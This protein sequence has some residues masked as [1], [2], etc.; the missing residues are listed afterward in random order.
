MLLSPTQVSLTVLFIEA[1]E[2][3]ICSMSI[4]YI[5]L[6]TLSFTRTAH[7]LEAFRW[8]LICYYHQQSYEIAEDNGK[9]L[10][11]FR[12]DGFQEQK[13]EVRASS[14]QQQLSTATRM[15]HLQAV[16]KTARTHR[17]F[18]SRG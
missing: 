5:T 8:R 17:G 18:E 15:R 9:A 11:T 14:R 3:I 2:H 6:S 1:W 7:C 4:L 13:Q 16:V 12:L 10:L